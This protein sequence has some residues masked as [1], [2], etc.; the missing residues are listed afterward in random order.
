MIASSHGNWLASRLIVFD[1]LPFVSPAYVSDWRL[2]KVK[3][4]HRPVDDSL[5]SLCRGLDAEVDRHPS[6]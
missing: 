2:L 3:I 5:A 4:L 6:V 1:S